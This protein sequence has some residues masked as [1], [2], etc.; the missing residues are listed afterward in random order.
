M[1][2]TRLLF[3]LAAIVLVLLAAGCGGRST[4][5]APDKPVPTLHPTFTPTPVLPT[6]TPEPPTPTPEPPTPTP[7]PPTLTSEPP[8]ATTEIPTATPEPEPAQ[9]EVAA[10]AVNLRSGP[11]TGFALAGRATQGQRLPILSRTEAGDWFQVQS[12]NGGE[13]WVVNDPALVRIVGDAAGVAVAENL[14]VLPTPRPRPRPQPTRP[15]APAPT[16][17]PAA[18][19]YR[20]AKLS[21][22]PRINTNLIITLFGG[23]Y[24]RTLN[25]KAAIGGYKM[26]AVAP[27]GERKEADFGPVFLRGNPGLG[28]EFLYNAKIE[29]PTAEGVYRVFVADQGGNPVSEAWETSVS[30]DMRTFLPRWK[31]Q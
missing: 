4:P 3:A 30:G 17:A 31:E 23:L 1:R 22:D 13:A 9:V 5:V 6:P 11:A 7:E 10:A 25:L 8:P 2:P 15:P 12:P 19:T 24:D 27:W 14:P 28:D 26:V 18:P 29:F 21:L 20:F 16:Q